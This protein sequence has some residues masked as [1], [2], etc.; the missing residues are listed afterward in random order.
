MAKKWMLRK[1]SGEGWEKD[2]IENAWDDV[3][4]E[5]A[6]QLT[7]HVEG[8]VGGTLDFWSEAEIQKLASGAMSVDDSMTTSWKNE[9]LAKGTLY[10]LAEDLEK[11]VEGVGTLIAKMKSSDRVIQAK[12]ASAFGSAASKE[13]QKNVANAQPSSGG[14]WGIQRKGPPRL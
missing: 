4:D 1:V 6:Q 13:A 12:A 11:E 14:V 7:D 8:R 5:D 10:I 9:P 3:G 2:P